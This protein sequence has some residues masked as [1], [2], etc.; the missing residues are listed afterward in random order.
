[1]SLKYIKDINKLNDIDII[2]PS[3]GIGKR[4]KSFGPKS[5]IGIKPNLNILQNQLNIINKI[6]PTSNII[7]VCGF[8]AKTLMDNSPSNIIK[9]ENEKYET[10]NVVRSIGMGLRASSKEVL[11]IYGDLVFNETCLKV[12]NYNKS[13]IL[14]GNDIMNESE[15][16][17]IFNKTNY[18]EN[19]MYDL[20]CKWG[21]MIFLKDRELSIFKEICWNPNNYNMFGFEAIN[22]AINN[23]ANFFACQNNKAKVI[24]VDSS[25]DLTRISDII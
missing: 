19:M 22:L 1:M 3:A 16:G 13:S 14:V 21:Q 5:L 15:V 24:D 10:T 23:G 12:M 9:I 8:E 7:L 2:I 20:P 6:F 11:I 25:K 18:I 17:C 4:M